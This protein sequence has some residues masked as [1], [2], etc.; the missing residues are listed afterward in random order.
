MR[1][2]L[3]D[4]EPSYKTGNFQHYLD[5]MTGQW[6]IGTIRYFPLRLAYASTIHKSQGLS[7][8]RVQIDTRDKFFSAPSMAYVAISRART[9]EGL[10]LVGT[11]ESIASKMI[12]SKE[13]IK[14]V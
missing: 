2:N 6:I 3:S 7:L 10:T 11:P 8:D 14:Y 12:M 1:P 4:D 5:P 9:P 13:V